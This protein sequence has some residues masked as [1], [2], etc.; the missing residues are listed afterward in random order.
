MAGLE[1]RA[2]L[3]EAHARG[4]REHAHEVRDAGRAREV[5]ERDVRPAVGLGH[6]L[7]QR[8]EAGQLGGPR[9]VGAQHDVVV[10]RSRWRARSRRRPRA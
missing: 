3:V 2:E 8:V 4:H 7:A 5:G 9:L 10:R 6:L 1:R